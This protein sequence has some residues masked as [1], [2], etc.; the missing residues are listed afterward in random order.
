MIKIDTLSNSEQ[1]DIPKLDYNESSIYWAFT[2]DSKITALLGFELPI[3]NLSNE[4]GSPTKLGKLNREA[5]DIINN[6]LHGKSAICYESPRER[7][8]ENRR[9]HNYSRTIQK[10]LTTMWNGRSPATHRL[11]ISAPPKC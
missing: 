1:T 4:L 6:C 2:D 11:P 9:I 5:F 10:Q 3:T 7:L 8:M